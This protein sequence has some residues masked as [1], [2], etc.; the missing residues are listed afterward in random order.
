MLDHHQL[1]RTAYQPQAGHISTHVV[2]NV[3]LVL[4]RHDLQ[5]L[6]RDDR[7]QKVASMM[8][9]AAQTKFCLAEP[10]L[11]RAALLKCS[12]S[13]HA[14][15]LCF[16]HLVADGWSLDLF[17]REFSK[18]YL[19]ALQNDAPSDAARAATQCADVCMDH[20]EWL[21]SDSAEIERGWWRGCLENLHISELQPL[22]ECET[23][24]VNSRFVQSSSH[25]STSQPNTVSREGRSF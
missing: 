4:Q 1:L 17:S 12:N 14:L 5:C 23:S 9:G 15:L 22:A 13:E 11:V 2:A 21:E 7:M 6:S 24:P 19:V 25:R 8:L 10:P 3:T 16:H 18:A 20:T